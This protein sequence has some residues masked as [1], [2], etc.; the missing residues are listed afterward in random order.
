MTNANCA[1]TT[2]SVVVT[3]YQGRQ[4][5]DIE[6]L[7][8]SIASQL[9]PDLEVLFV[10]EG[11][12]ALE[13]EIE[14][15]CQRHLTCNYEVVTNQGKA[16]ISASRNIGIRRSK[17]RIVA[18][19][20]D[21]VLL[22]QQWSRNLVASLSDPDVGAVTG[23]ATP[24]PVDTDVNWLPSSFHWLIG[25]TAWYG[26]RSVSETRAVWGM[27]MAF[28]RSVFERGIEFPEGVGGIQGKRIHGEEQIVCYRIKKELGLKVIFDPGLVV[29]HKVYKSRLSSQQIWRNSFG[30]GRTRKMVKQLYGKVDA[31]QIERN[32]IRKMTQEVIA[33]LIFEV[34]SNPRKALQIIP[35]AG[36]SLLALSLGYFSA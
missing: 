7:V 3:T 4:L 1:D 36:L 14:S 30:M 5:C 34:W 20:D 23:G 16:G 2:L 10:L 32:L 28:Q 12:A 27:N 35:V 8:Q 6:E 19:V 11:S 25:S 29:K 18:F 21:D 22:P 31:L 17:G 24:L 9:T 15:I 13:S 33:T 26:N